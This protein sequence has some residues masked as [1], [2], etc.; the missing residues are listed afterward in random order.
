MKQT[1]RILA[2]ETQI[3]AIKAGRITAFS[4]LIKLPEWAGDGEG[5]SILSH[6]GDLAEHVHDGQWGV[7]VNAGPVSG[8]PI[9]APTQPGSVLV[10]AR[11]PEVVRVRVTSIRLRRLYDLTDEDA[12]AE[13]FES[14]DATRVFFLIRDNIVDQPVNPWI[15][16]VAFE[17]IN[18]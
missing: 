5:I 6:L 8:A 14:A 10:A 4:T 15:W 7:Y 18:D 9:L 12:H 13:G 17:V 2:S 11:V 1:R 3:E 16:V